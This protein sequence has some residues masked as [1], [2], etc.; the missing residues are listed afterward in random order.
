MAKTSITVPPVLDQA[1]SQPYVA[2]DE[3]L[4]KAAQFL[5]GARSRVVAGPRAMVDPQLRGP[6]GGRA[7]ARKVHAAEHPARLGPPADGRSPRQRR[8]N[9]RAIGFWPEGGG[10]VPRR[11]RDERLARGDPGLRR[12]VA[13]PGQPTTH[14]ERRRYRRGR[15]APGDGLRTGWVGQTRVT[16][17]VVGWGR[18]R[19]GSGGEDAT[20]PRRPPCRASI[21]R[22]CQGHRPDTRPRFHRERPRHCRRD[23]A[24][25]RSGQSSASDE[26]CRA[27][28]S[29]LHDEGHP[30]RRG[31]MGRPINERNLQVACRS[32]GLHLGGAFRG[33][34]ERPGRRDRG[35]HRGPCLERPAARP[36]GSEPTD[37]G[38]ASGAV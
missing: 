31:S 7:Q 12:R 19:P 25:R 33:A 32:C 29:R 4:S 17:A 18:G 22:L 8:S 9:A 13:E 16:P 27:P 11:R 36:S 30:P 24:A 34:L 35:R 5:S 28:P 10:E 23:V 26:A 6:R 37:T 2:L 14:R 21:S 3:S 1:A 38:S 15:P 20:L